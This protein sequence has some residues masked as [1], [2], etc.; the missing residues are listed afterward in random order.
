METG[1]GLARQLRLIGKE[2][3]LERWITAYAEQLR[4]KLVLGRYRG[5]K[6]WWRRN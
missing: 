5:T 4:P 1:T 6:G 2:R 3:L